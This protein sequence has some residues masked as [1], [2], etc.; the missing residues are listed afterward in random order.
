MRAIAE[1]TPRIH[2]LGTCLAA[3][4]ALILENLHKYHNIIGR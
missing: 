3:M 4:W 1:K 2:H